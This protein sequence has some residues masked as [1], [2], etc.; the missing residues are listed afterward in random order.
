MSLFHR[1]RRS[2]GEEEAGGRF[3]WSINFLGCLSLS[4]FVSFESRPRFSPLPTFLVRWL[5]L[6]LQSCLG[7]SSPHL[8]IPLSLVSVLAPVPVQEVKRGSREQHT[9]CELS[10]IMHHSAAGSPLKTQTGREL[11]GCCRRCSTAFYAPTKHQ[12]W[13]VIV[14]CASRTHELAALCAQLKGVH[15]P[16]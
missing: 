7:R 12:E 11:S 14:A 10:D 2:A 5:A 9:D 3:G 4:F 1:M 6:S 16:Q 8:A 13:T 15:A